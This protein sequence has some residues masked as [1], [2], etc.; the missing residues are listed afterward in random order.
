MHVLLKM[1]RKEEPR[2]LWQSMLLKMATLRCSLVVVT[3]L[4]AGSTTKKHPIFC[5]ACSQQPKNA[6]ILLEIIKPD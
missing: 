3:I 1:G 2:R 5:E 4:L 6:G